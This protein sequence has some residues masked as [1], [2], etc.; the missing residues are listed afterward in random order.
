V[1][2][3]GPR[4]AV[5]AAARARPRDTGGLD[6]AVLVP[7]LLGL[8]GLTLAATTMLRKRQLASGPGRD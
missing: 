1:N 5:L 7:A 2:A 4:R 3:I 8:A 6:A